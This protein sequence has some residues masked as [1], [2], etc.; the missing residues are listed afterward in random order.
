[1]A[2]T[3]IQ[4]RFGM[5]LGGCIP[6]RLFATW[7]AYYLA[8]RNTKTGLKI[9]AGLA[10][11]PVI[12]WAVILIFGLRKTGRET[13]GSPIWWNFMRPIHMTMYILFIGL[14]FSNNEKYQKHAWIALLIDAILGLMAFLW[15]H[16]SQ[17][18]I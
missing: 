3:E 9:L 7:L 4:K 14:V 11:A 12:G 2:L 16:H 18:N 5:F 8:R 1:M 17:G 15:Y 13:Q 6:T 10:I